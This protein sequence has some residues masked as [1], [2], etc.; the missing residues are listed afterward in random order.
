MLK[1][2]AE[3]GCEC[4][5]DPRK[6]FFVMVGLQ[7]QTTIVSDANSYIGVKESAEDVARMV[8]EAGKPKEFT[9]TE[10]QDVVRQ[11]REVCGDYGDND[12]PDN[13]HLG[14]VI[15]KHLARNLYEN[16]EP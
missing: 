5:V 11:L 6:V 2:T 10:R 14:D 8:D 1:L 4:Y 9:S 12:W 7:G 15:E 3:H 13:L 16:Y